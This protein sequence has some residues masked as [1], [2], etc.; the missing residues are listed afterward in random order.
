MLISNIF[1]ENLFDDFFNDFCKSENSRPAPARKAPQRPERDLQVMRTDVKETQT[2]FELEI[3]LPGYAKEDVQA[4]LKD[5]CLTIRAGR[6]TEQDKKEEE[7][8][9]IRRE[10]YT[11]PCSRSFYVGEEVTQEDI[12]ARFENGI[13]RIT[14]PKKEAIPEEKKIRYISI[15]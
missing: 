15:E 14:V 7:V 5:G 2:S 3:D 1:G 9:Y 13:L 11:G 4:E 10:R 12:R 8:R 6:Q